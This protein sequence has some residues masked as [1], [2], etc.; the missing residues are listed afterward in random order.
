MPAIAGIAGDYVFIDG[1][2]P[3]PAFQIQTPDIVVAPGESTT[4]CYYF[5]AATT[6]SIGVNHWSS[7]KSPG[8][9]HL[10]AYAA[11]D[12]NW[13]PVERQPPGTLVQSSC[14]FSSGG[15]ATWLYAAH[16]PTQDL[17][18]P[19]DD[20]SGKALGMEI[21][22]G[23]PLFVE[24]YV[25]NTADLPLTATA[26]LRA[27]GLPHGALY[28]KMATYLTTSTNIA[29]GPNA[30]GVLVTQT[31]PTPANVKFWWL[32]TRTHMRAVSSRI[33]DGASPLVVNSNWEDPQAAVY[34][35]PGFYTF[36]SGGLTYECTYDNPTGDVIQFGESEDTNEV[37]M[38]IGYFFPADHPSVCVNNVGPL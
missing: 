3:F 32:S 9:H 28:A 6:E 27:E 25:H 4:Y 16:H 2:D 1:F 33:L 37:C 15:V 31:C 23:Q 10:I 13:A 19:A 5:R 17:A 24:I 29:I 21:Q 30:T 11:Y 14:G 18:L 8:M 26:L 35:Q 7:T 38:G 36:A 34:T 20:G 12:T 22:S